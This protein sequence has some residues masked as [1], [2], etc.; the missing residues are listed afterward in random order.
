[1]NEES[2]IERITETENLTD[3][4]EDDDANWLLDWG[5][6]RLHDLISGIADEDAAGEKVHDLMGVMRKLNQIAGDKAVKAPTELVEDV[7]EFASLFAKTFGQTQTAAIQDEHYTTTAETIIQQPPQQAMQT[8][9]NLVSPTA[10]SAPMPP[11]PPT[12]PPAPN[13][14]PVAP[15]P[16]PKTGALT[17]SPTPVPSQASKSPAPGAAPAVPNT[18][19][20]PD[21]PATPPVSKP[22]LAEPKPV[23]KDVGMSTPDDTA[24]RNSAPSQAS[25]SPA[26]GAVPTVP[27][28]PNKPD[29]PT[30]PPASEPKPAEPTP[31]S[32]D[33][34]M[35]TPGDTD[36]HDSTLLI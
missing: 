1:M 14:S 4:L 30:S 34:S 10:S 28:T 15:M 31:E 33:V 29:K 23:S 19:N 36:R 6:G 24:R 20:K 22:K 3:S 32:N 5:I 35:S 7:R 18:P 11:P 2:A 27:N 12:P 21:K 13:P 9:I 26:P 8:L 16:A 25:K 17:A